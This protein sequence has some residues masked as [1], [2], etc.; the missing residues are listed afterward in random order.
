[1][2]DEIVFLDKVLERLKGYVCGG[3]KQLEKMILNRQKSLGKGQ[4][5]ECRNCG[6]VVIPVWKNPKKHS[7]SKKQEYLHE[8]LD[9]NCLCGCRLPEPKQSQVV[10]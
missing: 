7:H 10:K 9:R 2:D 5:K 1:M 6:C 3:H 8:R 4:E